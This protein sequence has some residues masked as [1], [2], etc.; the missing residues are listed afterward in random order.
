MVV[1]SLEQSHLMKGDDFIIVFRVFCICVSI[2]NYIYQLLTE[3]QLQCFKK[4]KTVLF[5][6]N[7]S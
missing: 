6:V 5:S 2:R 7:K 4:I 3:T 1:V